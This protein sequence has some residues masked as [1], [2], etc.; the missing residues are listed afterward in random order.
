ME[1]SLYDYIVV[2]GGLTGCVIASRLRQSDKQPKVL[3]LEAG[4]DP[5]GNPNVVTILG[6]FALLGSE[7][8]YAYKTVPQSTTSGR[9]HTLN[10]G[11][12]LGGGSTINYG[13]WLRGDA[14]D[15]DQWAKVVGDK[16]WSYEGMLPWFRKSERFFNAS[17]NPSEHGFNG[18]IHVVSIQGSDPNRQ[19]PLR[20]RVHAAWSELGASASSHSGRISG[21]SEFHENSNQGLRQPSHLAYNLQGVDVLTNAAVR[22]VEFR[23][24][25]ASGVLLADGRRF[26]TRKEVILCA[27]SLR[28]PQILMLSGVGPRDVLEEYKIPEI[29]AAPQVGRNLYDHFALILA[30]KL[31]NPAQ[32]LAI[33]SPKLTD[34]AFFKGLPC[35]WV[36]NETVPRDILEGSSTKGAEEDGAFKYSLL[37]A[38]SSHVEQLTMYTPA[39]IPGILNDGSHTATSSMLLLPTS[40]GKVVITSADSQDPP[41]IDP[42]YYSTR[43]DQRALMWATRQVLKAMLESSALRDVVEAESPPQ[44]EGLEFQPLTAD[45]ADSVI[46]DRIQKTGVAHAHSGGTAAMGSVTDAE[47]RVKGV[48]GL[49]V[50]DASV[51]PIPVGGHPQSTLYAMAEQVAELIILA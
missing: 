35:D 45:A 9:V 18:P 22:R 34:P 7:L 41:L 47:C 33:G 4:S 10:A 21:I 50:A 46:D 27:G 6:G 31:R 32:G 15:Y 28:T 49:R 37:Q 14:A 24:K 26:T 17:A 3:L 51:I 13:G 19:Y 36:V 11:K 20:D 25:T 29:Y 43:V 23:D 12:A 8:D 38:T 16:R 2:G 39:G 48:K 40:R 30:F 1:N 44:I 42:N 5:T